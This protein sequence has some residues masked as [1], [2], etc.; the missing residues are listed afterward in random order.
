[1]SNAHAEIGAMQ[2]AYDAGLTSGNDMEMT[3]E[4]EKICSYCT[5]AILKMAK[6]INLR[7]LSIFEKTTNLTYTWNEGE[8]TLRIK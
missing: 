1:M 7:S 6:A 4:G 8:K 5:S 2:Q 3:V